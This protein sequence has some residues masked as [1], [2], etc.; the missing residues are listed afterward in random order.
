MTTRTAVGILHCAASVIVVA[1]LLLHSPAVLRLGGWLCAGSAAFSFFNEILI[2]C[3]LKQHDRWLDER[4]RLLDERRD[5]LLVSLSDLDFVESHEE[6][7]AINRIPC[8]PGIGS[9]SCFHNA[10]SPYLRCAV[11]PSGPC[12][13]CADFTLKKP[14]SESGLD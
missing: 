5:R 13:G 8:N 6:W 3:K 4:E 11:N 14:P 2:Y 12:E 1:G 10:R 9:A 7:C